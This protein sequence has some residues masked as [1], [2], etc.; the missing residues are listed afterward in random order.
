MFHI[1]TDNNIKIIKKPKQCTTQIIIAN[2]N[3]NIKCICL[4]LEFKMIYPSGADL[5]K[6]IEMGYEQGITI[7]YSS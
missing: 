5:E 6:I 7:C 3:K 4:L 2:N 1:V